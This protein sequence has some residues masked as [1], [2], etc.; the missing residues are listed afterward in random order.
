MP[1]Q[2]KGER[3]DNVRWGRSAAMIAAVLLCEASAVFAH[4]DP[5]GHIER[6]SSLPIWVTIAM[7]VS[8]IVIAIGV[9]FFVFRLIRQKGPEERGDKREKV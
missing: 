4:G 6:K 8:W 2:T 1:E 3:K 9:V 5:P 7:I